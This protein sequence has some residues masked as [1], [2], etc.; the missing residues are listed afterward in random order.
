MQVD[1]FVTGCTCIFV[2]AGILVWRMDTANRWIA[3][4]IGAGVAVATV[5]YPCRLALPVNAAV[6]RS[7]YV[8]VRTGSRDVGVH[9]T[10]EWKADVHCARVVIVAIHRADAF[11]LKIDTLVSR[12]ARVAV[13]TFLL[14]RGKDTAYCGIAG[15][16][17][18][19][20]VIDAVQGAKCLALSVCA[21][22]TGRTGVAV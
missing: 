6:T 11:A 20:V 19:R 7:A 12:G 9:T 2:V 4:I 21:S 5:Q 15:I 1:A 18:A 14:V 17:R 22:V 13:V 16:V 10:L 3:G 8:T